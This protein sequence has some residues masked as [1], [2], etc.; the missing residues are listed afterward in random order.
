MSGHST[1]DRKLTPGNDPVLP[2]FP[3]G[4]RDL[5]DFE[6]QAN[7]VVLYHI[8]CQKSAMVIYEKG[9]IMASG[10]SI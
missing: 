3:N 7:S 9:N 6:S 8:K 10:I 5:V 2:K 1:T 4:M